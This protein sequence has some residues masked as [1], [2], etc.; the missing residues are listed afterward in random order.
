MPPEYRQK[1]TKAPEVRPL[2]RC[3]ILTVLFSIPCAWAQLVIPQVADGGGWRST[4]V[5]T[6]TTLLDIKNVSL[7]FLKDIPGTAAGETGPWSPTFLEGGFNGDLPAGASV[8]LHT[9]GADPLTTQGWAQLASSPGVVAYVIY[10][11]NVAGHDQD[12]TA[13]AVSSASR[14]MVP[15]DNTKPAGAA[16]SLV[17]A[18]AVVNPNPF[19]VT[20]AANFELSGQATGIQGTP[21]SLP[22]DGQI[23]FVMPAQ[24]PGTALQSGLAEFY[25]TKP[26]A[27]A[28]F[29]IIALRANPTGG[30]TSLKAYNETGPPIIATSGG[31]GG[32][33]GGGVPQGD[34]TFGGF[35]IGKT[36][37]S[38]GTKEIVVGQFAAYTPTE[39]N[40][41][42]SGTQIDKCLVY[43]VTWATGTPPP[44]APDLLLDAGA[45]LTLTGPGLPGGSINLP[46]IINPG[47][48]GPVYTMNL[49]TG[50]LLAGQ[51]YTLRG[52]GGTEVEQFVASAT[53]PN[54]FTTNANTVN[55]ID[56]TKPLP[57]TWTGTGFDNV[58]I[59]LTGT[60]PSNASIH[61]VVLTCVVTANLGT[62]SIPAAALSKL[63][64]ITGT[65]SGSASL[66][67][68]TAPAISGQFS[69]QS[70]TT[71]TTI[72]PNLKSG[73]RV[74]YG[75]FEPYF[76]VIQGVLIP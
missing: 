65:V 56:R 72:T 12:A 69:S 22:A 27:S 45:S 32:G 31:G 70:T 7:T 67:V 29:S 30:F 61:Q 44:S 17:T 54:N 3:L 21:I 62:Y 64:S 47:A 59:S 55:T 34:I 25:S 60:A 73:G 5:L 11:Q 18:L 41:P 19:P 15:F 76:S 1:D 14:I 43:D 48:N 58:I 23:A 57:V 68:T 40:L 50:T 28:T 20:I 66:S 63:P 39:W 26:S 4:V 74:T 75:G 53:L 52:T 46:A 38:T 24:F 49:S 33:G 36:T 16:K 37:T 51:T 6:N 8:Y 2:P 71:D 9:P 13:P 35:S 42:F 10:T